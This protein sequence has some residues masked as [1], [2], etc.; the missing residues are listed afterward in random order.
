MF[1]R[2]FPAQNSEPVFDNI[3]GGDYYHEGVIMHPYA[4]YTFFGWAL[5][6]IEIAIGWFM[7]FRTA[8]LVASGSIFTWYVIVPM[9]V[10]F[11]VPI[12]IPGTDDYFA[13]QSAPKPAFVAASRVAR[14]IAIGAILG[15]GI[16]AL[17]KMA[18]VFKTS[19]AD[20]MA[21]GMGTEGRTDYVQGRGWLLL[22]GGQ[23]W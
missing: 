4:T 10:G 9:A 17:V 15:G 12:W 6:P 7:R 13:I 1:L 21:L 2:D 14:M 20:M 11:N 16:T 22:Q 23:R 8:L 19:I 3:I 18:K 5:I